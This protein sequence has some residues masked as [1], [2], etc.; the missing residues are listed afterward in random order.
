MPFIFSSLPENFELGGLTKNE[1]AAAQGD[2]R[3]GSER[4]CSL[5]PSRRD[6]PGSILGALPALKRWANYHCAYGATFPG[7]R[8][9]EAEAPSFFDADNVKG[10]RVSRRCLSSVVKSLKDRR[11]MK[12]PLPTLAAKTKTRRGWG[13][14]IYRS[15][16]GNSGELSGVIVLTRGMLLD[17]TV[18]VFGIGLAGGVEIDVQGGR[19]NRRHRSSFPNHNSPMIELPKR[20][21]CENGPAGG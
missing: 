5:A 2:R 6:S 18:H 8:V 4:V 14:P 16:A 1:G 10:A 15:R 12:H 9:G 19:S 3:G 13:T 17:R 21:T 11:C 7:P 20:C